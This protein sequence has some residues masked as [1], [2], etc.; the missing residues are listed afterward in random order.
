MKLSVPFIPDES[1]LCFLKKS[2]QCLESV[3]FPL[4]SGPVLDS[5]IRVK[6]ADPDALVKALKQFKTI[7]K[8]CLLNS[9]FI[10]PRAYHD[11]H[12]LSQTM[13]QLEFLTHHA[14][15]NGFVFSDAY[16]LNALSR[17]S[18][19]IIPDL[20]AV[21][22][23]NCM[24]DSSQKAF[25]FFNLIEDTGFKMPGKIALDRSL[26]RDP[27]RLEKTVREIKNRYPSMKIEVL[28][29]EGC[30]DLCPFKLT[31]DA[32]ISFSNLGL[33]K[34]THD[35]T[36]RTLGCHAYFFKN[37]ERFFLSPFIRPED[38]SFYKDIADTVK[39]C[40]R[41]LGSKFLM[42][43]ISAYRDASYDGNLL[44]LVDAAHWLSDH[45]HIDNKKLD[46][47]FLSVL[48]SCSKDCRSCSTCSNLLL[49]TSRHKP[50]KIKAYEDYL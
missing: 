47:G 46:P 16:F 3:Y 19:D 34:T 26:N 35:L 10:D 39:L 1:Y 17:T 21:P 50:F 28:A 44:S 29:N 14:G 43:C 49:T 9:R 25:A 27:A 4:V 7:K 33:S 20:E 45:I 38:L 13:D 24:M 22:G 12:F 40:G 5:R 48:T 8:Y 30:M 37:P 15:I 41:T 31:H 42:N 6:E 18:R 23:I 36:N 32:Q 2:A 11:P